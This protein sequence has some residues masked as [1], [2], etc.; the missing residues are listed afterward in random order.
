MFIFKKL[1]PAQSL[2]NLCFHIGHPWYG[3]LRWQWN[4]W[5][6]QAEVAPRRL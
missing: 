2:A 6:R 5:S 1:S 4:R 3:R